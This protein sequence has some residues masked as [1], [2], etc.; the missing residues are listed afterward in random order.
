MFDARRLSC[1]GRGL[2]AQGKCS[3]GWSCRRE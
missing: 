1:V 3:P 2:A